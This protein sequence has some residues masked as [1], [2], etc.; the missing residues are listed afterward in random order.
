MDARIST[1]SED[2]MSSREEDVLRERMDG[3]VSAL[4]EECEI[5][6]LLAVRK[7]E[8]ENAFVAIASKGNVF[9][10]IGVLEDARQEIVR[11]RKGS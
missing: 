4:G 10:L 9:E 2:S 8:A 7:D 11:L 1:Q 5:V 6:V 3:M